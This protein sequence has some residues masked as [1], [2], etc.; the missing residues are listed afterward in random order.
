[1]GSNPVPPSP[2]GGSSLAV[3]GASSQKLV[4]GA[5]PGRPVFFM[6]KCRVNFKCHFFSG[7]HLNG[8][9][10]GKIKQCKICKCMRILMSLHCNSALF[11]WIILWPLVFCTS[12]VL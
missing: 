12:W 8:T 6:E 3:F 10:F 1:M 2:L 11:G 5:R 7:G 9:N 4:D